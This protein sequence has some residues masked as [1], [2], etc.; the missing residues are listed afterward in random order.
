MGGYLLQV[1]QDFGVDVLPTIRVEVLPLLLCVIGGLRG[2]HGFV[3]LVGKRLRQRVVI[4]RAFFCFLDCS[5][6]EVYLSV[7]AILRSILHLGFKGLIRLAVSH[8]D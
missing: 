2:W 8:G 1:Y 5:E 3:A 7:G 4:V 6:Y